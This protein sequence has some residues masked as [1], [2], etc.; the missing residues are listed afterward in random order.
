MPKRHWFIKLHLYRFTI[1]TTPLNRYSGVMD[2]VLPFLL[3]MIASV[4]SSSILRRFHLP[5]VIT[6]IIAGIILGPHVLGIF[7][8]HHVTDFLSQVGVIFLMFMAG[9][10]TDISGFEKFKSGLFVLSFVNGFIPL[11]AGILIGLLFGYPFIVALLIGIIFVNSSIAVVV[12]SL[13]ASGLIK[14]TLGKS[15][16]AT[17]VLQDV[18]SMLLLSIFL[19]LQNPVTVIPIYIF[20]PM[21][22]L[23][24]FSLRW[25]IP[26]INAFFAQKSQQDVFQQELRVVFILLF[27]LVIVFELLGLH[28][29]IAAFLAGMILA[30]SV[31]TEQLLEKLHVIGYGVF[32]PAFFIVVGSQLDISIFTQLDKGLWV[33]LGIAL[34]SMLSKM[35][36]GTIGGL[37]VG[38]NTA[39]SAFFGASSITQ[40]ST[41][42]AATFAAQS[43]G[44]FPTELVTAMIL[45]SVVSTLVGPSLMGF[46]ANIILSK[47]DV[48]DTTVVKP[49]LVEAIKSK[50]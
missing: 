36:S 22:A 41:T 9:L 3:I 26:K 49:T 30:D 43:T 29:I 50:M 27:G 4:L 28:P 18:S 10:E 38:F 11:L 42:L 17:S 31:Q 1:E 21:V 39:Q 25:F 5:W 19:Q 13:E 44:L 32:V 37:M 35:L 6:L 24:L 20:Y 8:D 46:L 34:T 40:L 16:V 48:H 15:V 2:G 33:I 7:A 14:T 12:P 45:L 47:S 23:F